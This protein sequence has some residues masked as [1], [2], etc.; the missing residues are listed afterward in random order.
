MEDKVDQFASLGL[1]PEEIINFVYQNKAPVDEE[2]DVH[3][4]DTMGFETNI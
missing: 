2:G 1:R 4:R 3:L